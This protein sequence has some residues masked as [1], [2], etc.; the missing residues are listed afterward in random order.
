MQRTRVNCGWLVTM[1]PGLETIK[2]GTLV[3]VG[4]RIEHVGGDI[5][6]T[7]DAD[8]DARDMIVMPGLVNAHLHTWQAGLRAIG[9]EWTYPAYQRH[10]HA[11]LATRFKAEDNYLANLIGAL[12]QIDGGTTTLLDWCHNLTSLE[13]A[14]RSIDG[15]EESGIRA[16]FAHGTAKPLPKEG[17]RPHW[18][19]PHPRDRIVA[20]RKGRLASDDGLV[21]LAMAVLGPDN[22][23]LEVTIAD[24]RLA[25]EF[26]LLST[27][28]MSRRQG[29]RRAPE[30]YR[31]LAK[32]GLLGPDHNVVHGNNLPG[33]E[34][35]II[36]GEGV[37]ITSTVQLELT[38]AFPRPLTTRVPQMGGVVSLGTDVETVMSGD[39]IRETQAALL[40]ARAC[41]HA[42]V[43]ARGEAPL[44]GMPVH[45]RTALE[46]AT[47][48][49]AKT[50]RMADRIGSLAP[51]KK[52]DI[53]MLRAT[54][55]NIW[56]VY[57]P[58]AS[59]LS[60]AHAGNVDTVIIDGAV[61]KR[62]GRLTFPA[63][64]LEKRRA[65]LV[66]SAARIMDEAGYRV[67]H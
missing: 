11:N 2:G 34:L 32:L 63:A 51:G 14:E 4:D 36:V 40:N 33:E 12:N 19:T 27:A 17:E 39:M 56:P 28:H 38:D 47:I 66:A 22:G 67:G 9:A 53:I 57:D 45:S 46:W 6:G 48:N 13:M 15:L 52:A 10:L 24:H 59:I 55:P 29:Q 41:V 42:D 58:V 5:E 49:G 1:E 35:Q 31:T 18:E 50:L 37:T 3:F 62:A 54:D 16:V 44:D 60:Q 65:E 43:E 20:I 23:T 64:V 26:D 21:T 61:R 8:I 7:F 30:G 25:R